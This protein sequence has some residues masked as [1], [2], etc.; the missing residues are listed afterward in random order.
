VRLGI[1][2]THRIAGPFVIITVPARD[3]AE[4]L[5]ASCSCLHD[6]SARRVTLASLA[7]LLC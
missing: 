1:P 3:P 4:G 7:A 6:A 2:H 5:L